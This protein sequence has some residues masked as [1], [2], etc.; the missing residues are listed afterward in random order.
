MR[1]REP[2]NAF[3]HLA[4]AILVGIGALTLCILHR[5][6]LAAVVA[7]VIFG[8]GGIF[9]YT[10]SSVY[11]WTRE[12]KE[13]L[14]KLDHS[15]IFVMIAAT[16]TPLC[17]LGMRQPES[18][19]V[20]GIQWGL[21]AV[22]LLWNF[23]IGK[24]PIIVRLILY[25]S[26]G[27]MGLFLLPAMKPELPSAVLWWMVAGGAIYTAGV[28]IYASK[29]PRLWPGKFSSHELWHVFVLLGTGSHYA[30]LCCLR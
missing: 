29:R 10:S 25:L 24:P 13:G 21:A 22:G 23:L 20:L 11:H 7:F 5:D 8:L 30:M 9:L 12:A 18:Y 15:A 6:Q 27:W 1:V 3:S 19:I 17:L 26:M 14:Q 16:Y 28:V 4:G 2:F